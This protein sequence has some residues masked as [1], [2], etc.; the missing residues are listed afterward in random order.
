MKKLIIFI[1]LVFNSGILPA[2]T[3]K[4]NGDALIKKAIQVSTPDT[5]VSTT[6][7]IVYFY[8]GKKREFIVKS[9]NKDGNDKM[10]FVYEKPARV[11]GDKFLFLKGGDIWVFFSKTGRIRRIASSAKKSKMQGSDFSYEDMS[12]ISSI[13]E[14]FQSKILRE[15]K[16]DGEDCYI[17]ESRPIKKDKYSYSHLVSW[18]DKNINVLRKMEYYQAGQLEKTLAQKEYKKIK[19]FYIPYETIMKSL[20]NDTRTEMF[21]EKLEINVQ[22]PDRMFNKNALSR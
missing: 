4:I 2:Q 10:L 21:I 3:E 17:V 6:K 9:W 14:D 7:Q 18:I 1:V 11:K 13:D 12:M 22:V 20:K 19:E 5:M 8:T 16:F 15:E